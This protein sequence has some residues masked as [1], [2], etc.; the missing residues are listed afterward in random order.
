VAEKATDDGA[1]G[2]FLLVRFRTG[3]VGES[4][5]VCHV[6]PVPQGNAVPEQL[7]ALCGMGIGRGEADLLETPQGMPCELCMLL[8]AESGVETGLPTAVEGSKS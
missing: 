8:G 4:R 2:A 5:R 1:S 6:V 7:T 3:F